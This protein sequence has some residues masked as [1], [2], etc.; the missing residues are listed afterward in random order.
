M[1]VGSSW[2][3]PSSSAQQPCNAKPPNISRVWFIPLPQ[4]PQLTATPIL[5]RTRRSDPKSAIGVVM[6]SDFVVAMKI[7]ARLTLAPNT[8]KDT[9]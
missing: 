3:E 4:I 8:S 6:E 1:V 9:N 7:A 5:I 2:P